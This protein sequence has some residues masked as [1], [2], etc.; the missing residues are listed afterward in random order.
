MREIVPGWVLWLPLPVAAAGAVLFVAYR[1]RKLEW[2]FLVTNHGLLVSSVSRAGPTTIDTDLMTGMLTTIMDFAKTSFS[3]EKERN[4]EG[5]ELGEK[6]IAIVRGSQAYLAVVYRGR[7]P[8]RLLLIMRSL[9]EQ[10]EKRHADAIGEIVDT[11]KLGEI[12]LLLQRLVTR[13]NL[14]FVSFRDMSTAM[15]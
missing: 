10:V 15:G 3:D 14:P 1:R 11:S 8:G 13:G 7:T 9:L 6:R 5:L 12:P 2:A 4:L